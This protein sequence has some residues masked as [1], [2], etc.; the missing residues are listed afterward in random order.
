VTSGPMPADLQFT[1]YTQFI[2][3]SL[4]ICVS[5]GPQPHSALWANRWQER[6]RRTQG[7]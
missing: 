1:L 6:A 3:K 7:M 2:A 4:I 5:S